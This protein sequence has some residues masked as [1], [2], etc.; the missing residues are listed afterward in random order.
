[1]HV[2]DQLYRLSIY[3]PL[4]L[5]QVSQQKRHPSSLTKISSAWQSFGETFRQLTEAGQGFPH[6][7]DAALKTTHA[8]NMAAHRMIVAFIV[9]L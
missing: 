9:L 2:T 5:A 1:M 3:L 6:G 7:S 4:F 8:A